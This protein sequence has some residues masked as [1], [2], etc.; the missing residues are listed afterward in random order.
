MDAAFL[1]QGAR[2]ARPF[3]VLFDGS[4]EE[5]GVCSGDVL[6]IVS[7][8]RGV[9]SLVG[10]ARVRLLM[11]L[12]NYRDLGGVAPA[13]A[14]R[15]VAL[16]EDTMPGPRDVPLPPHAVSVLSLQDQVSRLAPEAAAVLDGL[17]SS[18]Q[19]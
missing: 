2:P 11:S 5:H 9:L 14:E 7:L 10:R 16:V 1:V 12:E 15:E 18:T 19:N 17:V 13:G 6:Y 8:E 3:R 4:F